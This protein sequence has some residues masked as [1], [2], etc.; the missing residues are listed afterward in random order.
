MEFNS[1]ARSNSGRLTSTLFQNI[2]KRFNDA[3]YK[4]P[5]IIFWNVNNRSGS[6][7]VKMH[8]TF[9]VIL[10]SGFSVNTV[11]MVLSN[12]TSPW[13]ALIDTLMV[14]RYDVVEEMA[15]GSIE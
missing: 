13:E 3:G 10:V 15:F 14:P 1:C 6:M 7:P 9:P 8:E 12:K 2:N 4:M 5:K 11:K